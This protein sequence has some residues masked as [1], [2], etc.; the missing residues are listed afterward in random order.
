MLMI[1]VGVMTTK[2][3]FTMMVLAALMLLCR[4]DGDDTDII[5]I[6]VLVEVAEVVLRM[7]V[8]LFGSCGA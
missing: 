6:V 7:S 1:M 2:A 5:I 8:I 4:G 3:M